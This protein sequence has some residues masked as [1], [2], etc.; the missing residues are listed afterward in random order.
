MQSLRRNLPMSIPLLLV[1][2][3]CG[4]RVNVGG[5]QD[6]PGTDGGNAGGSPIHLSPTHLNAPAFGPPPQPSSPTDTAPPPY[7]PPPTPAATLSFQDDI[8]PIFRV[9]CAKGVACHNDPSTAT[10]T[11][12]GGG[13]PYLGTAIDGGAETTADIAM[14]YMGLFTPSFEYLTP[15]I[16]YVTPG[17]PTM[18]Y[19]MFKMDPNLNAMYDAHCATGDFVGVCGLPM[20]SDRTSGPLDQA[21]RDKVRNWI[22]QGAMNN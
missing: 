2:S 8:M 12:P 16:N 19:L 13:R 22:A 5:P 7:V 11:A 10:K 1:L 20:P 21:T 6:S 18:S 9:N 14:V 4:A 15:Q 3:A 17:D